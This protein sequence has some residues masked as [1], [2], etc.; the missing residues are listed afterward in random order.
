[1][2]KDGARRGEGEAMDPL[3]SNCHKPPHIID[4]SQQRVDLV[5]QLMLCRVE[6]LLILPEVKVI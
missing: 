4:M 3:K 1:M 6:K 5:P 2:A